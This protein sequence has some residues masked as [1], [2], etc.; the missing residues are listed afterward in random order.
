M[1]SGIIS[2][3]EKLKQHKS[4]NQFDNLKNNYFLRKIFDILK[5]KI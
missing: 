2:K 1:N 3:D 5:K 4:R